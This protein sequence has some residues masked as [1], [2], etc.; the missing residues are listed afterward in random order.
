[1]ILCGL[2][3]AGF[4]AVF[5]LIGKINIDIKRI[6]DQIDTLKVKGNASVSGNFIVSGNATTTGRFVVGTDTG[7]GSKKA[8]LKVMSTS[9]TF[10]YFYFNGTV[11]IIDSDSCED[12]GNNSTTT[13]QIGQ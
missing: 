11:Q 2:V 13:I 1:M 8:C 4:T 5:S 10:S 7:P 6:A 12:T 3:I 9:N